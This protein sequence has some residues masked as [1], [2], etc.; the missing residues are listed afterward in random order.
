[1]HIFTVAFLAAFFVVAGATGNDPVKYSPILGEI[2]KFVY[3]GDVVEFGTYPWFGTLFIETQGG[4]GTYVCGSVL[5]SEKYVVTAAHCVENADFITV[6]FNDVYNPEQKWYPHPNRYALYAHSHPLYDTNT[7]EYDIAIIELNTPVDDINFPRLAL[8][9][10]EWDADISAGDMLTSIGHGL[11]ENGSLDWEL[12]RVKIPKVSREDC[13]G[14]G[15]HQWHSSQVH[16]DLCAGFT[17]DCHDDNCPDVCTGDS[18]GPL[19]DAINNVVY[20][21]VSRGE[22]PCGTASRPG[23]FTNLGIYRSFV[24][25]YV[26]TIESEEEEGAGVDEEVDTNSTFVPPEE[27]VAKY[28]MYRGKASYGYS[29][30][31]LV[32]I[33]L[34][35]LIYQ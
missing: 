22:S 27:P 33:L 17:T 26:G 24:E 21:L 7:L 5:A 4:Y 30:Q 14:S 6:S 25:Y 15:Y 12:R 29:M 3:L 35:E 11:T 28:P 2:Q 16:D 20:G 19:F 13:I 31:A 18:G 9:E 23:I 34:W 8:D 10:H 32:G 1:M